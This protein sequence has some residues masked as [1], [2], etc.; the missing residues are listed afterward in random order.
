MLPRCPRALLECHPMQRTRLASVSYLN[1][2][3]LTWGLSHGS[4][5][6]RYDLKMVP[7]FECAR[8]LNDGLV[9]VALVPSVEFA[10]V[11]GLVPVPGTGVTSRN[12]VRSV[13]L[14]SRCDPDSIRSLA[15]DLNSRTSVAL[16][17]LI[18]LHRYH[19]RPRIEAMPPEFESMLDR[20]DAALLIGDAAL[21][22]SVDP[23]LRSRFQVLDLARE[24][25][26]MTGMP[27]VF[28]FWAC[29]PVVNVSEMR[30]V[31]NRS[32]DEGLMNIDRIATLEAAGSGLPMDTI[33]SVS[34][35]HL[36]A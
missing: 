16:S 28:A 27:F 12:E 32:L 31:L 18:L 34:Y 30:S 10:R 9:D 19:C 21:R 1:A 3:P 33:A 2:L 26:L 5:R 25:N 4:F 24:W 36:R 6:G 15:V 14:I 22:A 7:P 13:L 20:H 8:L 11:P 23:S 29:R 35:T 17:R